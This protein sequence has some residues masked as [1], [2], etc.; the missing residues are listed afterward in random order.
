MFD[1]KADPIANV[2]VYKRIAMKR[3][4]AGRCECPRSDELGNLRRAH[5]AARGRA[6]LAI[7]EGNGGGNKCSRASAGC[8]GGIDWRNGW[9]WN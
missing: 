7:G 1:P 6:P 8:A 9:L 4:K 2:P 5:E 3:G